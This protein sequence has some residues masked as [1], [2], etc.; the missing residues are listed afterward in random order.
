MTDE[1]KVGTLTLTVKD[2]FIVPELLP[3][4]SNLTD[5]YLAQDIIDKTQLSKE[6]REQIGLTF[7][8]GNVSWRDGAEANKEVVFSQAELDLLDRCIKNKSNE[9][10]IHRDMLDTVKKIKSL[11]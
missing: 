2:R 6:E 8:G 10:Q 1:I 4:R 7:G 9:Q 3:E 11:I 5:Q